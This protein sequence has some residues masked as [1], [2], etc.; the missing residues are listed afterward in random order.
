MQW[1]VTALDLSLQAFLALGTLGVLWGSIALEHRARLAQWIL[2]GCLMTQIL[3]SWYLACARGVASH[4]MAHLVELSVAAV[5]IG[6]AA[7]MHRYR[8]ALFGC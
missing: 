7:V 1:H 8:Y 6:A 4:W 2:F 5:I 3:L